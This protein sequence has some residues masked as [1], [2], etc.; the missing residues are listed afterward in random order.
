[1]WENSFYELFLLGSYRPWEVHKPLEVQVSK[2]VPGILDWHAFLTNHVP[3]V[4]SYGQLVV[5][6]LDFQVAAVQGLDGALEAEH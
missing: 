5:G 4:G 6:N 3:R 1:M 2:A